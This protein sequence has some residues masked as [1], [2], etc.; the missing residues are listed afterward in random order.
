MANA[1]AAIKRDS[2]AMALRI[3]VVAASIALCA[4]PAATAEA[5]PD[6]P[7]F[8]QDVMP[9]FFRAGCNAGS[10][11]GAS[12]GKDGFMLSLFGYDPKGDYFR[13]TQEMVGRRVNVAAPE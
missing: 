1:M 7:S 2:M 12:R 11:H 9:V 13:I 5:A 8:R 10:C 3:Y 6:V 4:L